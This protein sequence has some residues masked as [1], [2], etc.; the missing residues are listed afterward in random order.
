[1]SLKNKMWMMCP[2]GCKKY[3]EPE[4]I[5]HVERFHSEHLFQCRISLDSD[6]DYKCDTLYWKHCAIMSHIEGSETHQNFRC[7]HENLFKIEKSESDPHACSLQLKPSSHGTLVQD[8][9]I[10]YPVD[11]IEYRCKKCKTKKKFFSSFLHSSARK[12]VLKMHPDDTHPESLIKFKC[13]V[14]YL[15]NFPEKIDIQEHI[16]REHSNQSDAQSYRHC[17][18]CPNKVP[19]SELSDHLKSHYDCLFKCSKCKEGFEEYCEVKE[20]MQSVHY[21]D[22]DD[23][24]AHIQLPKKRNFL[25]LFKCSVPDCE[26]KFIWHSNTWRQLQVRHL[27]KIHGYHD[28]LL[29]ISY[30]C[31]ICEERESFDTQ[32]DLDDHVESRH[33]SELFAQDSSTDNEYDYERLLLSQEKVARALD[34]NFPNKTRNETAFS[35]NRGTTQC[36]VCDD[37]LETDNAKF[38]LQVKHP[39]ESFSCANCSF[40]TM[41]VRRMSDHVRKM[42]GHLKNSFKKS[43]AEDVEYLIQF[44]R[45]PKN[46]TYVKCQLCFPNKTLVARDEKMLKS[47]V[48]LT[49]QNVSSKEIKDICKTDRYFKFFCRICGNEKQMPCLKDLLTHIKYEHKSY[50]IDI[51]ND[52][53]N[54]S[55]E[56]KKKRKQPEKMDQDKICK[57]RRR[58][59]WDPQKQKNQDKKE[60]NHLVGNILAAN[61]ITKFRCEICGICTSDKNG[62]NQ[63]FQGAKHK[64]KLTELGKVVYQNGEEEELEPEGAQREKTKFGCK[65][66]GIYT[67]DKKGLNQ[68]FKGAKHKVEKKRSKAQVDKKVYQNW[69]EKVLEPEEPQGGK[70]VVCEDWGV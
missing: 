67:T 25:R 19:E 47:H 62:L 6:P 24:R 18:F 55:L 37:V 15:D 2:C 5:E 54:M 21:V 14:C 41:D 33:R 27:K 23:L 44:I 63:H 11:L 35:E 10:F 64:K 16:D 57:K 65:T 30:I 26:R 43:K 3:K 1:M 42:N 50:N 38:H 22:E 58:N 66:C 60:E 45:L 69:E 56:L 46:L 28:S 17:S 36:F 13:R 34:E 8:N 49:H 40:K 29:H 4:V 32:T 12:H 51:S 52:I 53:E 59:D 48:F 68:H 7:D 70:K 39:L 31:R 9:F 61:G 20:H